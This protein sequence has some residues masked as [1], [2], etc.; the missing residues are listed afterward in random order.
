MFNSLTKQAASVLKKLL[1]IMNVI[2][3]K[4]YLHA[5]MV[6]MNMKKKSNTINFFMN[7]LEKVIDYFKRMKMEIDERIFLTVQDAVSSKLC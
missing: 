2:I 3:Y 5:A 1:E 7:N 4:Y 6:N